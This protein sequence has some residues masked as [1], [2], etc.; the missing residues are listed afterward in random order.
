MDIGRLSRMMFRMPRKR[1]LTHGR[2]AAVF[3]PATVALATA[4]LLAHPTGGALADQKMCRS[5]EERY[6]QIDKGATSIETNAMLFSAADKGCEALARRL[7]DAGA[8]LDARDRLGTRPLGH[9]AVA[10]ET[11]LV[12][13]FLDRGAPIN[14]QSLDGSTALFQ[15]AESGRP[16]IVRQLVER[17]AN[18]SLPGRKG[19]MPLSAA[20]YMGSEPVV[21][22]L[23]EKGADP[24]AIDETQKAAIVYAAGRGFPGITRLLLDHGVDVNTRYGNDLTALMWAAGYTDEAGVDDVAKVI[25]LLIERGA[26]LDDQDN[27]GRTAL[28]TAAELGHTGAAELLI[29]HG[30]NRT[31]QDKDGK[32]A[33]DLAR[34][35]TLRAELAAP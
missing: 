31:L 20:T 29:S 3:R 21:E 8:S 30:A 28:M 14:A 4:F 9:A 24:K 27:R 12:T 16:A 32:T 25:T 10:G 13:L 11:E 26:R 22:L 19:V 6:E 1:D 2:A 5:L 15:A 33:G 17:G 34:N 7:L 35:E 23:I 18:V